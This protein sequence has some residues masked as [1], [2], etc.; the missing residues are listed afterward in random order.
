VHDRD[1][2]TDEKGMTM[3]CKTA[4]CL[5]LVLPSCD[6][7]ISASYCG[8]RPDC[9][10]ARKAEIAAQEA[11]RLDDDEQKAEPETIGR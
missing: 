6:P 1:A 11:E 2:N 3:T 5:N 9:I 4:D 7:A 8:L 10:E